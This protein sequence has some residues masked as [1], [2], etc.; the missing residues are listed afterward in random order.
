MVAAVLLLGAAQPA[1]ASQPW[2]AK[3]VAVSDP[4]DFHDY[5]FS[6][7]NP[8]DYSNN[9]A[10]SGAQ[11]GNAALNSSPQEL[12]GVIGPDVTGAWRITTGRP[13]V[14]IAIVD[15]GI[16][17][18]STS[19]QYTSLIPKV[20]LNPGELPEPQPLTPAIDPAHLYDK[21]YDG[22]FNI[23]DYCS[24]ITSPW[25][26]EDTRVTD[27]NSNSRIDPEDLI[28]TPGWSNGTDSDANGYVDDIAGWDAF[29]NDNNPYDDV[30]FGHGTGRAHEA[31]GQAGDGSEVGNCPSCMFVPVR[32]G[33]SYVIEAGGWA[34]GIVYAA[35][36][37]ADVAA[38]ALGLFSAPDYVQQAADYAHSKGMTIIAASAN[39]EA[40]HHNLPAGL[41]RVMVSRAVRDSPGN[42]AGYLYS[43][44][45]SNRGGKIHVSTSTTSC[46]SGSTGNNA[47]I[48]GLALSVAK[49]R[50]AQGRMTNY[51]RDDGSSAPY[52]LS[53]NEIWQLFRAGADDIDFS[54]PRGSDPANNFAMPP[55]IGYFPT[56]KWH[57]VEGWD[58]HTGYGRTNARR[59]AELVSD[60][61]T[62]APLIPPEAEI[63]SPLWF[64]VVPSTG[65]VDISGRVAAN[66]TPGFTWA[67]EWAPGV[68]P[69]DWPGAD[70]WTSI[71]SGSSATAV[72][73]VLGTLD[74]SAVAA[75][76]T[77]TG[78][79]ATP[80]NHRDPERFAFR[81]RARVVDVYGNKGEFQKQFSIH[82]DPDLLPGFPKRLGV[83]GEVSPGFADL[84]GDGRDEMIIG[85]TAGLLHAYRPDGSEA[86]GWPVAI[87]PMPLHTGSAGHVSGALPPVVR[88]SFSRGA[89]ALADLDGDGKPEV[90]V[91]DFE[92]RVYVFQSDGSRRSGFPVA[93]EPNYSVAAARNG[94]NRLHWAI[95]SHPAVGDLDGDGVKEIVAGSEDR[96]VY[97]WRADGSK[98]PGWPV[99]LRDPAKVASVNATNHRITFVAGSA[100]ARGT[101]I[102]TT[103]TLVD[104]TGDGRPEVVIGSNET[105]TE[106]LNI[107]SAYDFSAFAPLGGG[108]GRL[109]AIHPE[110]LSST[111]VPSGSALHA[112]VFLAGWP[113][114]VPLF[115]KEIAPVMVT[116]INS[117]AVA[118]DLNSD[119]IGEVAAQ[120]IAGLPVL[121]GANGIG[122]W[123]R[124]GFGKD[125]PVYG[126]SNGV[127]SSSPEP[128]YGGGGG[129]LA[130]SDLNGDGVPDLVIAGSGPGQLIDMINDGDSSPSSFLYAGVDLTQPGADGT[131]G[132]VMLDG[133]PHPTND[134]QMMSQPIAADLD[135][136]GLPEALMPSGEN[137]VR[138]VNASGAVPAGWGKHT[139]SW[140]MAV[141]A[142]GDWRGDGSQVAIAMT[143]RGY[144]YAWDTAGSVCAS[145]W[146]RSGHDPANTGNSATDASLPRAIT[147]VVGAPTIGGTQLT[148][149]APGDDGACGSATSYEVRTADSPVTDANWNSATPY[150][151]PLAAPS[152]AGAT[153]SL[154][155]PR[156]LEGKWV[157]LRAVDEAGNRT[158]VSPSVQLSA[159]PL[160][161]ISGTFTGGMWGSVSVYSK[162]AGTLVA[163]ECCITDPSGAWSISVPET[164]CAA[165]GGY[166]VLFLPPSQGIQPRWYNG[167]S[168]FT[169]A[170]CVDAPASGIDM[171]IPGAGQV[172]GYVKDA[173][174]ATDLAGIYLYAYDA[175]TGSFAGWTKTDATGRYTFNL[176]PAKYY[177]ILAAGDS[178][179]ENLWSDGGPGYAEATP[180]VAPVTA[181]FSLRTAG[182]ISGSV[183]RSGSALPGTLI[184]AY[185]TCGCTSPQNTVSAADGSYS[186]KVVS[187][188]ASGWQYRVRF[189]PS[190]G[191]TKWYSDSAG[192][193]GATEVGSP[194]AGINQDVPA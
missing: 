105:Y 71:S 122:Y 80:E 134:S 38:N 29:E 119:G 143:R 63:T 53:P 102:M 91:A 11:S 73:G 54:T 177:K 43:N 65:S 163:Y 179:H 135:G 121:Y 87:D 181:N 40:G 51:L 193:S 58:Q 76:I 19:G 93:V 82:D 26:C 112:N 41:E 167:K 6:A 24:K 160:V 176:D 95:A 5:L 47:G 86:T 34:R 17:W 72:N 94:S 79:P 153:E 83:S 62:A 158:R 142:V 39:E 84:D 126:G 136:D 21:N 55:A 139:G 185:T 106:A 85:D 113:V 18:R 157:A 103:P 49:N 101:K 151:S 92:G 172:T 123:G 168:N 25:I 148:F 146:P 129:G 141:P 109:F 165:G 13:D 128:G 192:F 124:D 114:K 131:S 2:P 61:V 8:S 46:S 68:Q 111:G 14:T 89:P 117:Q 69:P 110:G 16:A 137:D 31:A 133:F 90:T 59:M 190:S 156:S 20:R 50:V 75:V 37:G 189:R 42:P 60:S 169:S 178:V 27:R 173:S 9:I 67:L 164:S 97:A 166:A 12:H 81:V 56:E 96:H 4:Y 48:A 159:L 132:G 191:S 22:V 138:A 88:A 99:L 107:P 15:D 30:G 118:V 45:C 77:P 186:V 171:V 98:L 147:D 35:D 115:S 145:T 33:D 188:A 170:D 155:L 150:A 127:A 52:A 182:V 175:A 78:A 120:G 116:G 162:T 184:S 149:V 32:V 187:T 3:P 130:L 174:S 28:R 74:M 108:N 152:G 10:Q 104:M 194:S 7:T 44:W 23:Q 180:V 125:L 64:D 183:T 57:A 1:G 66:R 161:T 100:A 144:L 70:T 140:N 154:D 36:T